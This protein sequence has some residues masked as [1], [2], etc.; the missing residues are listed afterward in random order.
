M[1]QMTRTLCLILL[2]L[3]GQQMFAQQQVAPR[4]VEVDSAIVAYNAKD[5]AKAKEWAL[6]ATKLNDKVREAWEILGFAAQSLN[7]MPT[8]VDAGTKITQLFPTERNGWYLLFLGHYRQDRLDL[9]VAPMR[10]LCRIDP[11][12]CASSNIDKILLQVSQD[13]LGRLDSTF[14]SEEG[15]ISVSL[16]KSWHSTVRSDGKTLNW[17]V[18]LE[19]I[20]SDSDAYSV[21]GT[22]RWIRNISSSFLI[23]E[24]N[25][26]AVFLV[27]FWDQFV[28]A[29]MKGFTPHLRKVVDSTSISRDGWSGMVRTIDFQFKKEYPVQRRIEAILARKDEV[30]AYTFESDAQRWA[31]YEPRFKQA[32]SSLILPR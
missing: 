28:A 23:E 17:F 5:F 31:V 12:M 10:E 11:A 26:N 3:V 18:T 27:D 21:G 30:F 16:P 20:E 25:N 9:A 19:K 7:D 6:K 14:R 15:A 13:S 32:I 2:A 8:V 4:P 1:N 29:Q 24:K 22:F